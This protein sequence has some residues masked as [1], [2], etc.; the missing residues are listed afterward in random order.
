MSALWSLSKK[1]LFLFD[2]ETAH[3]LAYAGVRAMA[4]VPGGL[5]LLSGGSVSR[6]WRCE[7]WGLEFMN[8]V[9]LA[10]GF[11]KNAEWLPYLPRMGFGFAEIGTVTPKPQGGNPRPR[12]TRDSARRALFNSMGFNNLGAEIVANRV[13]KMRD[14]GRI[15][16]AFRVGVNIGKN[17]TTPA[18]EAPQDYVA[19]IA[20]FEKAGVDFAVINVSSP[21]TPGLRALQGHQS[22]VAIVGKVVEVVSRWKKPIPVAV[23]LAPELGKELSPDNFA[24]LFV[25]V[26]GA[27]ARGWVLT[28]T[29]GGESQLG[30]KTVSGGWSGEPV[31]EASH[32]FLRRFLRSRITRLPVLSVGGIQDEAEARAR[33]DLGA[34]LVEVYTGWIFEGPGFPGR[35]ARKLSS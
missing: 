6:P 7:A 11:D 16:D 1:G 20:P 21:N 34:D 18:A 31:R 15:P 29:L 24:R 32:A 2:P 12:V 26:E 13:A 4:R 19:A 35:L 22:L 28:N 5:P 10:A 23:K 33:L 9:G 17:R 3:G 27:G 14:R 8:R 30:E 25:S